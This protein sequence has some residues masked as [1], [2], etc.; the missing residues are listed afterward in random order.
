M[1]GGASSLAALAF[2]CDHLEAGRADVMLV[3]G[4]DCPLVPEYFRSWDSLRLMT[5]NF[6][7]DPAAASRPFDQR[8]S[9]MVLSEGCGFFALEREDDAVRR[10]AGIY[11]RVLGIGQSADL[12]PEEDPQPGPLAESMAEAMRDA[13]LEGKAPAHIQ[14]DAASMPQ[15]DLVEARAIADVFAGAASEIAVS[16][17]KSMIGHTLGAAGALSLIA[18]VLGMR[19]GFISPVLN[20][21]APDPYCGALDFVVGQA[22]AKKTPVALVNAFGP[23]AGNMS[24]VVGAYKAP[25]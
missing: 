4:V 16:S 5:R 7:Q 13:G 20:L 12:A 19:D 6:N 23:G 17:I 10:G 21:D 14:A 2:A 25:K 9:G 1:A 18:V 22:R 15:E 11:A 8:R 24:V 3:G